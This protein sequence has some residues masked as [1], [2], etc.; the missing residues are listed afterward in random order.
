MAA[1][2]GWYPDPSESG[3]QRYFDGARWTD[4]YYYAT[5]SAPMYSAPP[6]DAALEHPRPAGWYPDP[7]GQ[8]RRRYWDGQQW[9]NHYIEVEVRTPKVNPAI[10]LFFGA[11]AVMAV[12]GTAVADSNDPG[13]VGSA[14]VGAVVVVL[15]GC[16]LWLAFRSD[17]RRK[18]RQQLQDRNIELAINA[19]I[20]DAAYKRG[21]DQRRVHGQF[22]LASSRQKR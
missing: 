12:I 11:L 20:E 10:A 22:P 3:R 16:G 6:A 5:T 13:N 14:V 4:N 19:D 7:H 18:K 21:D 9:T 15:F 2:P 8:A 1:A 17:A